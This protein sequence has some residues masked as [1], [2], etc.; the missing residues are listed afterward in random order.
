MKFKLL[1]LMATFLTGC[2][3]GPKVD[4]YSHSD[5]IQ[6]SKQLISDKSVGM[7]GMIAVATS[8]SNTTENTEFYTT[9]FHNQYGKTKDT[10]GSYRKWCNIRGGSYNEMIM[11][12]FGVYQIGCIDKKTAAMI[13]IGYVQEYRFELTGGGKYSTMNRF[14]IAKTLPE[15]NDKTAMTEAAAEFKKHWVKWRRDSY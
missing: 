14:L 7:D 6:F 10:L 9:Q 3:S 15:Q 13:Y 4:L 2:A 5:P 11:G 8:S 12:G 1:A